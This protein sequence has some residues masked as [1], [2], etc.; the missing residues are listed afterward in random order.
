MGDIRETLMSYVDAIWRRRWSGMLMAWFVC[1]AGWVVVAVMP[2]RYTSEARIYVDTDTL[3]APL[4]QGLAVRPNVDQQIQIMQRTLL[5]RPNLEQVLRMTDLDLTAQTVKEREALIDRLQKHTSIRPDNARN[6]FLLNHNDPDP[7]TA[8]RVVQSLLTLF[9]EGQLGSKR[10]DMVQAQA[11]LEQQIREYETNLQAAEQRLAEFK[12]RHMDILPSGGGS[13][14]NRV[15]NAETE[16]EKM[17]LELAEAK[18]RRDNLKQQLASTPQFLSLEGTAPAG[19]GPSVEAIALRSRIQDTQRQLEQLRSR[20]TDQHP[21]V[22]AARR[23]LDSMQQQFATEG[24]LGRAA[25]TRRTVTQVPNVVHEQ[26][27]LKLVDEETKVSGMERRV[28]QA[29]QEIARLKMLAQRAPEVEAQLSNLNR[30]YS[31]LKLNYEQLLNRRESARLAQAAEER[32]DTVQFRIVD[33]PRV[34]AD[35]SAPNRT[36]FFS[37]V[38]LAGFGAGVVFALLLAQ[39]DDTFSSSNRLKQ[40]FNLP[41]LGTV[42][43]LQT[44]GYHR[45]R[46]ASAISFAA[47]L[48]V[49]VGMYG[50][51]MMASSR[52]PLSLDRFPIDRITQLLAEAR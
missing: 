22:V 15:S 9:V 43:I 31:V 24:G 40:A 34:P 33:P 47:V 18:L 25:G 39:F 13:F 19:G 45:G 35:P 11:F 21:D 38:L 36:L 30:D 20:Y 49:L 2:N 27:K 16:R 41:V 17:V 37:G 10:R 52:L 8:Q 4:L 5:S 51:L 44:P 12:Q 14:S 32:T 48:I 1:V 46:V 3:L 23:N 50:T 6:L 42:S 7:R 26:V 28:E 29:N